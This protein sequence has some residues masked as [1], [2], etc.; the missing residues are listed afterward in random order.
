MR[1]V[2]QRR[3]LTSPWLARHVASPS[4]TPVHGGGRTETRRRTQRLTRWLT[5]WPGDQGEL[6]CGNA[7][8][9]SSF[10]FCLENHNFIIE[11]P[12]VV[13]KSCHRL[14][15][16]WKELCR[17]PTLT[18]EKFEKSLGDSE[19]ASLRT[20][21][22]TD[23]DGPWYGADAAPK[24]RIGRLCVQDCSRGAL[25][26]S[27]GLLKQR[28]LIASVASILL[29][30]YAYTLHHI[31][32][33]RHGTPQVALQVTPRSYLYDVEHAYGKKGHLQGLARVSWILTL[34]S[35]TFTA[36]IEPVQQSVCTLCTR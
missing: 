17:D 30:W 20:R 5:W 29:Y 32:M 14:P 18:S 26:G 11:P 4:R 28:D 23:L 36:Q 8:L 27:V 12:E 19:T 6:Q 15:L 22:L 34:K 33:L 10:C 35:E 2:M 3:H 7:K 9:N 21:T 31:A 16:C 25:S 1:H 13:D 24:V